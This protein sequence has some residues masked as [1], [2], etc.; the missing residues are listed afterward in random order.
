MSDQRKTALLS[1]VAVFIAVVAIGGLVALTMGGDTGDAAPDHIEVDNPQYDED[2]VTSDRAPGDATVEMDSAAFNN[3]IVVH[4]GGSASER[5]VSSLV[6]ALVDS[7]HDVTVVAEEGGT[8]DVPPIVFSQESVSQVSPPPDGDD[9]PQ[10]DGALEEAH[11]LVSV[12]V[13]SYAESDLDEIAEFVEDNGRV[14]MAVDPDQ[15][16]SFGEGQSQT[17]S[18][19]GVYTEPG[20]VYNL[21]ENDLNYQRIFAEPDGIS[22]LTDGVERVVFDTA[23]PVQAVNADE[24]MDPIEGSELSVT[25]DETEKPVLVRDGDVA[26]I[27]DTGFM[28]PENAQRADNDVLVGNIADF[29]VESNRII[30]DETQESDDDADDEVETVTV[31]VGPDGEPAFEPEF[32]EIEPGTTV[33]FVWVSDGYNLVPVFQEPG[34]LEWEGVEEVQDEGFVHE[35]TFEEEGVHEFV[36]EP[37]ENEGMMGVVIVGDPE[38]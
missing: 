21:A 3:E 35:H 22:I 4:V 37:H 24:T 27:G 29:L 11:G 18:E 16:F 34:D 13:D 38:P 15:E 25:R 17:Y 12:G 33:E 31:E 10:L 26:L 36:S 9:E 7:G 30:E 2:R 14:V 1:F 6:N 23:T 28:T 5:D 8:G 19:L 20:Y 32:V